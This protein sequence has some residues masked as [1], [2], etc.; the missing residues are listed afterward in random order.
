[1]SNQRIKIS[2]F[3]IIFQILFIIKN[4]YFIQEI[5]TNSHL[6]LDLC[7]SVIYFM[8]FFELYS[9]LKKNFQVNIFPIILLWIFSLYNIVLLL[10]MNDL[11]EIINAN[12]TT[13]TQALFYQSMIYIVPVILK[14]IAF[15]SLGQQLKNIS[16]PIIQQTGIFFIINIPLFFVIIGISMFV[17]PLYTPQVGS[18]Y[19]LVELGM[20]IRLYLYLL[21][22]PIHA[23]PLEGEK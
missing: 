16:H 5:Y 1:M 12:I 13:T 17:T 10:K 20:L 22:N 3:L 14:M 7:F 6:I 2:I 9:T 18:I 4:I 23:K 11:I 19:S 8:I 21:K 15:I